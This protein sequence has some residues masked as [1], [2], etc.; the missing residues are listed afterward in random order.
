MKF[1]Y[2][3]RAAVLWTRAYRFCSQRQYSESLTTLRSITGPVR[4]ATHWRLFEIYNLGLLGQDVECLRGAT[5]LID[6]LERAA[7]LSADQ[8]YLMAFTR[9]CA[10]ASFSKL[11]PATEMP[12]KF[13]VSPRSVSLTGVAPR[14]RRTFRL[15]EA[16]TATV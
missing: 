2:R 3:F 4:E 15:P 8:Q 10:Q 11:F 16:V 12:E 6:D 9:W 14:W 5:A 13:R 1:F 7:R